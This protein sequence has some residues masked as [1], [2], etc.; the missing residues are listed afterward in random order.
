MRLP[1]K[2]DGLQLIAGKVEPVI[3]FDTKKH[4]ADANGEPMYSVDLVAFGDEGPQI[5]PVKVAG[6]PKG[7]SEGTAVSVSGLVA[8]P[9]EMD[10]RHG[11]S[12]RA[13]AISAARQP[14]AKAA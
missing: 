11:I 7:I 2:T 3:D 6:E 13:S 5:W 12:F 10:A 14:Q 4:K 1:I 9:W 8:V